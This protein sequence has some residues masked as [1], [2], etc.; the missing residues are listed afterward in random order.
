MGKTRFRYNPLTLSFERIEF[1]L[2]QRIAKVAIKFVFSLLV[3][4]VF[5]SIYSIFFDT[6]KQKILKRTN[7]EIR[8][9][10]EILENK[11]AE[12]T[13]LVDA[14]QRRDNHIYRSIFEADTI[15]STI[16]LGGYG[17]ANR[18][19]RFEAIS[20]PEPVIR[21]LNMLDQL[22]W[23]VYIQSKSF[24]E[25]IEMAKNKEKMVLSIPAIQPVAVR[26][27]VKMSDDFGYRRDPFTREI[28][29]HTGIDFAGPIGVPIYATGNGVV[30]EAD[31]SFFGYGN[32]VVID[33]G[34]G[35]KSRYA[36]LHK[37]Q[38]Q[39]GQEVVRGQQIGLLGNSGRST[40]PHL[41]YEVLL[42]NN[43]V[44][45]LNY[46]NDMLP[47]EYDQM[48]ANFTKNIGAQ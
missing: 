25:V 35:Y 29:L 43:P 18:Y 41:H 42:R 27:L 36:H 11:I 8:L 24:D 9:R 19:N 44:N 16:R 15:P 5:L 28:K 31:F 45:P 21:T 39:V 47:H 48:V 23:K 17:G 46:F 20:N 12:A 22:T 26:D 37:I 7:A 3:A 38:V 40:G 1:T 34:F 30:V 2:S 14:M 33:H 32:Q 4:S 13:M 6:P 10:F